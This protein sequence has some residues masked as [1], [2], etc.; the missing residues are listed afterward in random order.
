MSN[1]IRSETARGAGRSDG[2]VAIPLPV[3]GSILADL[4]LEPDRVRTLDD[5]AVPAADDATS[6]LVGIAPGDAVARVPAVLAAAR[7]RAG[8]RG[9]WIVF[10][11]GARTDAELCALRNALWPHGHVTALYSTADTGIVRR[12]LEGSAPLHKGTGMRGV[13]LVVRSREAVMA[14]DA[15]VLKFDKNASSWNGNPGGPGYRHFRWM[16]AY[17]AT[18]ADPSRARRI[19]DFG[20]G[21]GWVGIEA[22]Q[23]ARAHG[24]EPYLAAF[25][26]SP[27]MVR[28]AGENARAAGLTR[29]EGRAGFGEE[30]PFPVGGEERFDFV[31]SSGVISFSYRIQAWLDGLAATVAPGGTLVVG[32]IHRDST[33]MRRRRAEKPLLPVREMNAQVREDVRRELEAR[34]FTFRAWGG[35]QLTRPMP[36]LNHFSER[37]LG[38]AL[39]RMLVGWNDRAARRDAAAGSP[40]QDR[41]DSWVMSFVAR[42]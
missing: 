39:D 2:L 32:D 23:V 6:V 33:G 25:D 17:V 13:A 14:P 11:Q 26:P 30:P 5:A 37:R 28:L 27:E 7:E 4:G 10:A 8:P 35:Y 20:C 42:S 9:A 21:A 1:A 31:V 38:G 3:V 22:A 12:T 24:A 16:R 34:G 40:G 36:Q 41:F 29:F 18:F 19:L 15:T